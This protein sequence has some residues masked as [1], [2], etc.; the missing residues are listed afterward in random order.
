M[1]LVGVDDQGFAERTL[2]MGEAHGTAVKAHVHAMVVQTLLAIAAS[3]TRARRRNGNTLPTAKTGDLASHFVDDSGDF[4]PEHH[5]LLDAHRAKTAVLEIMQVRT[6]DTAIGDAHAQLLRSQRIRGESVE[7][8]IKRRMTNQSAHGVL[9]DQS[10]A[11]TP[12]ST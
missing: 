8:Q 5:G 1:G 7:T 11:V 3:T 12:P 2:Y 10:V 6:A 9:Q 4:V